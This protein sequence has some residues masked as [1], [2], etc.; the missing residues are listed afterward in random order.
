MNREVNVTKRVVANQPIAEIKDVH[1]NLYKFSA[2]PA[3]VSTN[4]SYA[5]PYGTYHC[6]YSDCFSRKT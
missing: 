3:A 6:R 1:K 2:E 4:P 5:S